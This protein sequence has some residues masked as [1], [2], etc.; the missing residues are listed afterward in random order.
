MIYQFPTNRSIESALSGDAGSKLES[1]LDSNLPK[2]KL[3]KLV[4][5]AIDIHTKTGILPFINTKVPIGKRDKLI[6]ICFIKN[7]Y[8][9]TCS[10]ESSLREHSQLIDFAEVVN[11]VD[12]ARPKNLNLVPLYIVSDQKR[13][14]LVMDSAKLFK[15]TELFTVERALLCDTLV[16]W[17]S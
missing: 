14:I 4:D 6:E 9:F 8:F 12:I 3:G 5:L 17:Q 10:I 16:T 1:Y 2:G 7:D 15:N 13:K 11:F